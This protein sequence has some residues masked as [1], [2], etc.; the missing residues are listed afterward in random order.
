MSTQQRTSFAGTLAVADLG[1]I[2]TVV[3]HPDDETYL[4][5]GVMAAASELGQRV[6]SASASAGELGTDDPATWPPHR[7]ADV[8]R[9]EAAAAMAVLGVREHHV[10]DLPDG[11]LPERSADGLAW[12][13]G[14]IDAVQPDTILTFGPDG[15]TGHPDHIAV[16]HWVTEVWEQRGCA[17]RVLHATATAEHLDA[18]G[19]QYEEWG[20]YMTDDRPAGIPARELALHLELDGPALDRK[21]VALRAMA[22]QTSGIVSQ[23]DLPGYARLVAEEAF[24]DATV[25]QRRPAKYFL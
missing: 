14:L 2:L 7:L 19:E 15:V 12:V 20:V 4:A 8:R 25:A 1:T 5:A 22:T 24:V 10:G 18:F 6:V 23:L 9:L 3:A 21:L 16:H 17:A 13:G 11:G